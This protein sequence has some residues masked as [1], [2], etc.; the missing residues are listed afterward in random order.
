MKNAVLLSKSEH[1]LAVSNNSNH[2]NSEK[3]VG[4]YMKLK[5]NT[6]NVNLKISQFDKVLEIV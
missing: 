2:W 4:F 6:A 5:E 1:M 3:R